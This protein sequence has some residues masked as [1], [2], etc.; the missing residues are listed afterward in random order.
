MN[1]YSKYRVEEQKDEN[2]I[3]A[4][5]SS[6]KILRILG[7]M[8]LISYMIVILYTWIFANLGG[9]VYFSAGEPVL[10]IKYIEWMLGFLGI[11]VATYYLH[12]ELNDDILY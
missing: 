12:K 2:A 10:S 8:A 9:Y 6:I 4:K 5:S 1:Q 11:F 3:T 7:L